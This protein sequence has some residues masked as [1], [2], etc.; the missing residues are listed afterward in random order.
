MEVAGN[1]SEE[2]WHFS[3]L[4]RG[5]DKTQQKLKPGNRMAAVVDSSFEQQHP[6]LRPKGNQIVQCVEAAFGQL[7]QELF[8]A[9]HLILTLGFKDSIVSSPQ[10][11]ALELMMHLVQ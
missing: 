8:R 2:S 7:Y 1:L 9:V 11:Q 4:V 10:L 3:N 5:V 6:A